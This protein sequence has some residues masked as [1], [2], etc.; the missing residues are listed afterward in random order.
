MG[1][2][3]SSHA[4]SSLLLA[5]RFVSENKVLEGARD[6]SSQGL[7]RKR[8]K[9]YLVREQG[10]N[11]AM[12]L[13]MLISS[14]A[15]LF[16]AFRKLKFWNKWYKDHYAMDKEVES[17]SEFLAWYGFS[18]YLCQ[19]IIR[20]VTAQKLKRVIIW[21]AFM[22]SIVSLVF[23]LVLGIAASYEKEGTWKAECIAAIVLSV[24]TLAEGIRIV[25]MHLDDM[26]DRLRFD[27]RA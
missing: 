15:L 16:K 9:K 22:A 13:V 10:L 20:Y 8:R 7:L 11:I 27:S 26:D 17:V 19:A 6:G 14:A 1:I 24:V 23:L 25:I 12:A 21:H 2:Q 3:A 18:M 4:L 5:V